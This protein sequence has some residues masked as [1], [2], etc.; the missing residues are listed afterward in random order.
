[1][2]SGT[3]E[4]GRQA[5]IE[6]IVL[7]CECSTILSADK[8]EELGFVKRLYEVTS[9]RSVKSLLETYSDT[10]EGLGC[11]PHKAHLH[12]DTSVPPKICPVRRIPYALH[13]KLKTELDRMEELQVIEKVTTPTDWVNAIVP[14]E[15][16]NGQLRICLDPRPLNKAIQRPHFPYPTLDDLRSKV[17]GASVFSKLD[18]NSGYWM[19]QLDEESSR[20]CTFNTQFG[21]YKFLRLPYGI[22][23]SGEIFHKVM[24]DLFGDLPGVLIFVDDILVF[25]SNQKEHNERLENVLKKA[26]EVNLKFNKS[27]CMF[28]KSEVTYVGHVFNRNGIS[29]DKSKIEAIVEMPR[30]ENIKDLQR[31]LGMVNYLGSYIPNLANETNL[32]RSLLKKQNIWQWTDN[33]EKEFIKLKSLI[34]QSPVLVHYDV[35]KPIRM[36]VDSS[37]DAVGAV[38]FHGKNPI[39]YSSKSLTSTQQNYAQIERELYAIL[40]GCKKFHQYIYGKTIQVETDHQPL[41]TLF[42][43]PLSDVPARLQRMMI[44]LQAYDLRVSYTKGTEM[45][46]SD[47]L[48]RAPIS[49]NKNIDKFDAKE[50]ESNIV[51][52]VKLLTSNL[53]ISPS[54]LQKI[55]DHT[56]SDL[57]LLKLQEYYVNGWPNSKTQCDPITLPY[58]NIRDEIHAIDDILF[59]NQSVI[60]PKSM[61]SEILNI[62]HEGHMGVEK[63]KNLARGLVFWP[64][65]YHDIEMKVRQCETC[66]TFSQN[67]TKETLLSHDQPCLPWQKLATD[68]FDYNSKKYLLVV[69]YYSNY[70]EIAQLNTD[71]RSQTVIQ[72]LKSMFSR[73]GIPLQLVSDGGPPYNSQEFQKFLS[74]WDI[75]HIMSSPHFPR[76]NGLAEV[77]VKI[78]KNILRKCQDSGTDFHLGLLQY[79][80]TPRG[81]L[82]SPSELLMSRKLRTRLP[83]H[84]DSLKPKVITFADHSKNK[85]EIISK[86]EAYYNRNAI[87]SQEFQEN[88]S[89]FFKKNPND[90]SWTK[91]IIVSK[92]NFPR[93]YLVKSSEG[94]VYRRN[95]QHIKLFK[96]CLS[97]SVSRSSDNVVSKSNNVSQ[98]NSHSLNLS[99]PQSSQSSQTITSKNDQSQSVFHD[100][101]AG[102]NNMCQDCERRDSCIY[103][104]IPD[105]LVQSQESCQS[106]PI[107]NLNVSQSSNSSDN[108]ESFISSNSQEILSSPNS[109]ISIDPMCTMSRFNNNNDNVNNVDL[110]CMQTY[111]VQEEEPRYSSRGR[112][113]KKTNKLDL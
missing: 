105:Y 56:K 5:D 85:S 113:L 43:K 3:F 50:L 71:H 44:T 108:N 97:K 92:T 38:I 81:N 94:T 95:T 67:K 39:A 54:K 110:P 42:K 9:D 7:D 63:T 37:K 112:L 80:T 57:T 107:N 27:K 53:A 35:N 17:A 32:L 102:Q 62:L 33:H 23:S 8:S 29:A 68:L 83:T 16:S 100:Q 10:F 77:S 82:K 21:R 31:F 11:L 99:T 69:D 4:N 55:K 14:I 13:P 76:S 74:D 106:G 22:N 12:V 41:V 2:L 25:G 28:D 79:R 48:S 109:S 26:R 88:D 40:F 47:T 104:Y 15:K 46:V 18:A 101:G 6:F 20:L 19:I 60:I 98:S 75:E 103:Y 51:C 89:V 66:M 73:H 84:V 24:S 65:I 90:L 52:Q 96:S 86:R 70:I 45:Y 30:P 78:V 111:N 59:K 58:W 1:M 61:R 64:N 36:S 91:G 34:S 72:H 87:P 93:S 49:S